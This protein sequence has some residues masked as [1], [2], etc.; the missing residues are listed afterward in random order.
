MF[1]N[2]TWI[3]FLNNVSIRSE[4]PVH[5]YES[6]LDQYFTKLSFLA[7]DCFSSGRR[8]TLVAMT[9]VKH[10]TEYWPSWRLNALLL[11]LPAHG[12]HWL[13][14]SIYKVWNTYLFPLIGLAKV[15]NEET[16]AICKTACLTF[17]PLI[18]LVIAIAKVSMHIIKC[19]GLHYMQDR[20]NS[21]NYFHRVMQWNF[22]CKTHDKVSNWWNKKMQSPESWTNIFL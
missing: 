5:P 18:C 4:R 22:L 13:V 6:W 11:D 2:Y 17:P 10:R 1:T 19:H 21:L 16:K 20:V 3:R 12:L 9:L 8:M 15:Y 14:I 7:T